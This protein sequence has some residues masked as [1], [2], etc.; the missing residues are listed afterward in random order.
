MLGKRRKRFPRRGNLAPL[1]QALERRTLFTAAGTSHPTFVIDTTPSPLTPPF[2][3]AQI[4]QAYSINSIPDN[5]AGQTIAI[6]DAYNDP[7][8][9]SDVQTFDSTYS[10]Q[11][12]N[13]VGGPT[14]TVENQTGGA[15]PLPPNAAPG[16]W[17]LE[18]SLD[19]EWAHSLAP[20]ANIILF[21]ANSDNNDDLY[22]TVNTARNTPSVSVITMSWGGPEDPSD[23]STDSLFTTPA[24]HQGITF[25]ASTGDSGEPGG[26]PAYSPNILAVG[27]SSLTINSDGSYGGETAWSDGGGG[28]S[29]YESQ[30][31]YQTA[32]AAPFSTTQRT[33][34]DVSWLADPNTGVNVLDTYA[35]MGTNGW[36]QIGGTSLATPMWGALISM[37]NQG[38]AANNLP[39]LD[40]P[41]QTLPMLYDLPA[42]AFNDITTGNNGFAAGVGYDLASGL[43]TPNAPVLFSDMVGDNT[44]YVDSSAPGP[45]HDGSS[46]ADAYTALPQALAAATGNDEILVSQGTYY[47]TSISDPTAILN[48]Q[49]NVAINGGFAGYGTTNPNAQNSSLFPTILSGNIGGSV[50]SD[51]VLGAN[52]TNSTAILDG[53]TIE[54]GNSLSFSGFGGG[55][56]DSGGSPTITNS[57]FTEDQAGTGGAIYNAAAS[58][59]LINCTFTDNNAVDGGAITDDDAS[60]STLIHCTFTD[61][62]ATDGGAMVDDSSSTSSLTDCIFTGNTASTGGAMQIN[63]TSSPTIIDSTFLNNSAASAGAID[64]ESASLSLINCLIVGNNG[65]AIYDENSSSLRLINSTIAGNIA[66][67]AVGVQINSGSSAIITNCIIWDNTTGIFI[68][69]GT[70]TVTYSDI[71]GD[72][73]GTGNIDA[74]PQ[75]VRAPGANGPSDDG[76]EHLQLTSPCIDDGSNAAVPS[77][78][79]TDL[80]GRPRFVD[81]PGMHDPGAIVDMGA[82]EAFPNILYVDS[83]A[84]GSN[85]GSSWTNAFATLTAALSFAIAGETIEVAAG[86][87][88]PTTTSDRTATFQLINGVTLE[89]GFGGVLSATPNARNP[90]TTPTILSGDIGTLG[91]TS[92]NSY[93]VVTGSNVNFTATLDGFTITAGQADANATSDIDDAIGGGMFI[94]DGSPTINDCTFTNNFSIV[95]GGG[96]FE[97]DNAAPVISDC[98]FTNNIAGTSPL[99]NAFGG[100][101]GNYGANPYIVDCTFTANS[102][103]SP[104]G[105]A[106]GGAIE[107][108]YST[109][110]IVS[111]TFTQNFATAGQGGLGGA[112]DNQDDS[113]PEID[114]CI[115]DG[116][117]TN[118][119][120]GAVMNIGGVTTFSNCVFAGNAAPAGGA[121][122]NFKSATPNII[123]CTFASNL[124]DIGGAIVND[125]TSIPVITN[126][127]LWG[128]QALVANNEID[129]ATTD[130]GATI[131]YSDVDGDYTGAGNIN[132]NPLFLRSPDPG[133]DETWG[134]ADDYYGNLALAANSPAIDDGSNSA[135]RSG[136]TTDV[137]N[138]PRF[139]NIP[140]I[141]DP[142]VIV[143]LGAYERSLLNAL[144]FNFNTSQQ[145]VV[146]FSENVAASLTAADLQIVPSVGGSSL[147]AT[148]L[149][150]NASNNTATF[151]FASLLPA[152]IYQAILNNSA[153]TDAASN[154]LAPTYNFS[155]L[156][157][158]ASQTLALPGSAQV[159]T[160]QQYSIGT[161]STL[162]IGN[163]ELIV[164][165]T[166]SSPANA[167]QSLISSGLNNSTGIL[168]SDVSLGTAVGYYD[169]GSEVT[170]RRTWKGDANLDGVV[171]AD[172]LSLFLL[173]QALGQTSWQ[174]GNFNY[175]TQINADDFFA[176]SLG[177]AVSNG[178]S[179]NNFIPPSSPTVTIQNTPLFATEKVSDLLKSSDLGNLSSLAVM[180]SLLD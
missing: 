38:R 20:D 15:S 118:L 90:V 111:C 36:I 88:Y 62:T 121:M 173:G 30:P 139:V 119:A 103:N 11:T 68:S 21:E 143:D 5:G 138:D 142:G 169:D 76:D 174:F 172:D 151:G 96:I 37:V 79:T 113:S 130:S 27:G 52:G 73:L 63:T 112:I 81:F 49:N 93:H 105:Q 127:I 61:N 122:Y 22:A 135:V 70:A 2:T 109:P 89:G 123:N 164:Q 83:H 115:F 114:D 94:D 1:V 129:L 57:T 64:I 87:Y 124:A 67:S 108:E 107:N 10:L 80:D 85:T 72:Y 14:F 54:D 8:I 66:G 158:P 86:S 43:G 134:T 41:S 106:Q 146:K 35:N 18:E 171:N 53:V 44:L 40:G 3:P 180:P 50:N 165:Y 19:V 92:D 163:D 136:I 99:Y 48:L 128:D 170:I 175:D 149:S 162:D 154:A 145:I 6:I 42:N 7:D 133:T 126:S 97:Q 4:R 56:Y 98:T 33:I 147:T 104:D 100:A 161:A 60:T 69:A 152:G 155:F 160:V 47:P 71:E 156:Y 65:G 140:G 23:T 137:V 74:D 125:T 166:S 32:K 51:H 120:A 179:I 34:P 16:N 178:Q 12:F 17:D 45:T 102:A 91:N 78:I 82:F 75:F 132:S 13:V 28:I 116:N 153:I 9:A 157:I 25:I 110:T 46:W 55:L 24:G 167:I 148:T 95:Y 176:L 159:Y 39:T 101:I 77:N 84:T 31:D 117:T 150:Y 168:S 59:T 58:P 141:H 29:Q 131:T 144:S 26:Y 177:A